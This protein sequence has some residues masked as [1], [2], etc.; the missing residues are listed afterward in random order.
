[1]KFKLSKRNWFFIIGAIVLLFISLIAVDFSVY[2]KKHSR[3]EEKTILDCEDIG[4]DAFSVNNK[5]GKKIVTSK[6][7]GVRLEIP[8]DWKENSSNTQMY[9]YNL[10][11]TENPVKDARKGGCAAIIQFLKCNKIDGLFTYADQTRSEMQ[12]IKE[13]KTVNTVENESKRELFIVGKNEGIKY[14]YEKEWKIKNIRIWIPI[15]DSVYIFDSGIIFNEKCVNKF[16]EII[17]TLSIQ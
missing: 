6:E 17:K 10:E 5:D 11:E 13:G 2:L 4:E 9:F 15:N 7:N 12:S 3:I 1:M 14:S 16:N 8:G